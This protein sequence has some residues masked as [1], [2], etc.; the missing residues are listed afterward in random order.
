[1]D[2]ADDKTNLIGDPR[3]EFTVAADALRRAAAD[4]EEALRLLG[5]IPEDRR[6][7]V[8]NAAV[9]MCGELGDLLHEYRRVLIR[10]KD[11]RLF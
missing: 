11:F 8:F 1:M 9:R 5:R 7:S 4:L 3:D 2:D 6:G 10:M